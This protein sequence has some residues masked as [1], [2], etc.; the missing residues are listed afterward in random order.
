MLQVVVRLVFIINKLNENKTSVMQDYNTIAEKLGSAGA[1]AKAASH[2][3][4][5]LS[6]K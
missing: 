5:M 1:S 3:I 4:Q 2:I 6:Q